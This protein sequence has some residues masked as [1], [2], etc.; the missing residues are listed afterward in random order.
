MNEDVIENYY[1]TLN[2][3]GGS[4]QGIDKNKLGINY[5]TLNKSGGSKHFRV[6]MIFALRL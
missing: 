6:D 5:N 4:K 2:K 1:N 3:S